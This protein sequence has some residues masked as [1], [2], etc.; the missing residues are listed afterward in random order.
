VEGFTLY[1][2]GG[3]STITDAALVARNL[4]DNSAFRNITVA[5][6]NGTNLH[7]SGAC[8]QAVFDR[9]TLNGGSLAGAI[10]LKIDLAYGT[11]AGISFT[12]MSIDHPGDTLNNIVITGGTTPLT[13]S[14]INFSGLYM[15]GTTNTSHLATPLVSINGGGRYLFSGVTVSRLASNSTAYVFDLTNGTFPTEFKVDS[16]G[17]YS[18]LGANTYTT[19]GEVVNDHIKGLTVKADPNGLLPMYGSGGV[20]LTTSGNLGIG[21]A[22]PGV[23]LDTAGSVRVTNQLISTQATGAAPLSVSSTTPVPNLTVQ[24][25][26]TC[27]LTTPTIGG[28][29]TLNHANYFSTASIT[30]TAVT[31]ATCSDQTFTVAGVATGDK[32][33]SVIPPGALGNVSVNADV[34]AANT[35]RLHFCNPSAINVTPPA[36]VYSFLDFN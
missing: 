22:N 4:Y 29:S 3:G 34:S 12:N 20:V 6:Y 24:N 5:S 1:N 21:V 30:P 17:F 16:F 11:N 2:P 36:G 13:A 8:C 32:L 31:A 26:S 33:G 28:G 15:E 27:A 10:P 23:S 25:C 14:Q 9:I 19:G 35:V 7:V 18:D